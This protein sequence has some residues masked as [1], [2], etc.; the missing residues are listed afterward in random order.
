MLGWVYCFTCLTRAL[1]ATGGCLHNAITTW[2]DGSPLFGTFMEAKGCNDIG[3]E[4]WQNC[5]QLRIVKLPATVVGISDNVFPDCKLQNSVLASL[6]KTVQSRKALL[7]MYLSEGGMASSTGAAQFMKA[8]T[9]I[10]WRVVGRRTFSE[11]SA[12]H[13]GEFRNFLNIGVAKV[14]TLKQSATVARMRSDSHKMLCESK[15]G[16]SRR[17]ETARC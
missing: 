17:A 16:D 4:A 3:A 11:A 9:R 6:L 1:H 8:L 14:C 7:P 13:K 10:V 12:V 2:K 15:C 5:R